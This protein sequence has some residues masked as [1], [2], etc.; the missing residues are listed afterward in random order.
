MPDLET[1]DDSITG[2]S[3]TDNTVDEYSER[4]AGALSDLDST[5]F[6]ER[7]RLPIEDLFMSPEDRDAV[8]DSPSGYRQVVEPPP[9]GEF[10]NEPPPTYAEAVGNEYDSGSI[11]ARSSSNEST[12]LWWCH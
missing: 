10:P 1:A 12:F 3:E 4:S 8:I 9:Y 7:P 11:S 2:S 6:L 5:I